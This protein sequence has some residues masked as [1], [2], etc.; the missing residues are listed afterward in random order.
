[1]AAG[2]CWTGQ[3]NSIF[4]VMILGALRSFPNQS[5]HASKACLA[6]LRPD[7]RQRLVR[8]TA[9]DRVLKGT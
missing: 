3:R 1:C 2:W 6:E 9:I 5:C 4:L 8:K 7:G